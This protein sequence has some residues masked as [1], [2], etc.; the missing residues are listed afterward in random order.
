MVV[1]IRFFLLL[2]ASALFKDIGLCQGTETVDFSGIRTIKVLKI[3]INLSDHYLI[4]A[5]DSISNSEIIILSDKFNTTDC[6]SSKVLIE[7]GKYYKLDLSPFFPFNQHSDSLAIW[8]DSRPVSVTLSDI[9]F[10]MDNPPYFSSKIIK[11]RICYTV[12][13]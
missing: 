2:V 7:I 1:T 12:N 13:N 11:D 6:N 4:K 5:Q 9:T 10:T 3:D 8:F